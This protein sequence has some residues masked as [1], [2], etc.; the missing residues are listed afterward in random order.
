MEKLR[1]IIIFIVLVANRIKANDEKVSEI[2]N[3]IKENNSTS[4]GKKFDYRDK[5]NRTVQWD[6]ENDKFNAWKVKILISS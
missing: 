2:E 6:V 5:L 4:V 1:W 3:D